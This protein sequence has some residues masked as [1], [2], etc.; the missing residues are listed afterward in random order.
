MKFYARGNN[1]HAD[2]DKL[3]FESEYEFTMPEIDSD[4]IG[5]VLDIGEISFV[6]TINLKAGLAAPDFEITDLDGGNMSLDS[7]K[8]KALLIYY[9]NPLLDV[10]ADRKEKIEAFKSIYEK[11]ANS[12]RFE[13]LCVYYNRDQ[14]IIDEIMKKYHGENE[15]NWMIGVGN[16]Q[17]Y[18]DYGIN[19][20][21]I[22]SDG[23]VIAINPDNAEL[24][25]TIAELI[26]Q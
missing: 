8:D 1:N 10:S 14:N 21:L 26:S 19:D 9:W 13:I 4:N 22:G 15:I 12:D 7:F 11:F 3:L 23:K 17:F 16:S 5:E 18:S 24:E 2:W 25:T 6:P 20:V